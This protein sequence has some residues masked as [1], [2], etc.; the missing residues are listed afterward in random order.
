MNNRRQTAE[1]GL[2]IRVRYTRGASAFTLI[3]VL[4]T[5]AIISILVALLVPAV[6]AA[7]EAARKHTCANHFRQ[8]GVALHS[9]E[10]T[11][12]CFPGNGGFT[13]DS[14]IR[15]TAGNLIHISTFGFAELTTHQ[16]G[17]G[18]PGAGPREQ[19]G[20]WA[21][22]LLPYVEERA[23]YEAV[24]FR[25]TQPLFLCPTRARAEP[26]PT[27]EDVYGRYESGGWAW[28]KTD[29]AGNKFAFPNLPD[30]VRARDITGG[31]STTIAIGEKAYNPLR[32]L[33]SSWFWDEP[34]FAGGSDGTVRDG[35][36]IVEDQSNNEFRWNWGSAHSQ[37]A[38]FLFFDGSV[39]WKSSTIEEATLRGILRLDDAGDE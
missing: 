23:A 20:C 8:L 29:Y 33:P 14:L 32:Q 12:R 39:H 38:C 17:V 16:W 35:L 26:E 31:L 9:H 10:S 30:V 13:P 1:T 27:R 25:Q 37:V 24:A 19:P 7:R 6:Q 21:Y 15:D 18:R 11:H 5:I 34:L 36:K 4:V 2:A 22:A 3:E 28:A